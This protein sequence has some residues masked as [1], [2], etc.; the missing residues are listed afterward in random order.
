MCARVASQAAADGR[1]QLRA[2]LAASGVAVRRA[3]DASGDGGGA[4]VEPG[5]LARLAQCDA[6]LHAALTQ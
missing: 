2:L 1:R 4:A 5:V 6:R 3:L